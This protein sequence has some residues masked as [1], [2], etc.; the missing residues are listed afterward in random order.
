MML[1]ATPEAP[2]EEI[3]S[4]Q[5]RTTM[6][7]QSCAVPACGRQ[8]RLTACPFCD[9]MACVSCV[10]K[11]LL[12]LERNPRCINP[13]CSAD[14]THCL[15]SILPANFLDGRYRKVRAL[16]LFRREKALLP[17]TQE[18]ARALQLLP[19]LDRELELMRVQKKKLLRR[20]RRYVQL[21]ARLKK[22]GEILTPA[23][24][25]LE[26]STDE[27]R[28]LPTSTTAIAT[29]TASSSNSTT[30][31]T[32]SS[33]PTFLRACP[34]ESCRGYIRA[35]D[36]RCATCTI[37]VCSRC[38]ETKSA[39]NSSVQ[40]A[41]HAIVHVCQPEQLATARRL[42]EETRD[43]PRCMA[44]VSRERGGVGSCRTATC[45]RCQVVFHW[46]T[47]DV[48]QQTC[49]R[50]DW[51][52]CRW[53]Q[54]RR[55]R[56]TSRSS[57]LATIVDDCPERDHCSFVSGLN[58]PSRTRRWMELTVDLVLLKHLCKED[59]AFLHQVQ[60]WLLCLKNLLTLASSSEY[61]H[62][63]D[64]SDPNTN[65]DLRVERLN[66]AKLDDRT[67]MQQLW[68]RERQQEKRMTVR[69]LLA[70]WCGIG[71]E[72]IQQIALL[73][74]RWVSEGLDG[75][76][77]GQGIRTHL[78][79]LEDLHGFCRE[80]LDFVS[81]RFRCRV[82]VVNVETG[83]IRSLRSTVASRKEYVRRRLAAAAA[84]DLLA[85]TSAAAFTS[86][87]AA[88][89]CAAPVT[90]TGAHVSRVE[91]SSDGGDD[92]DNDDND[93]WRVALVDDTSSSDSDLEI[94]PDCMQVDFLSDTDEGEG[95]EKHA[96]SPAAAARQPAAALPNHTRASSPP[97]P[98]TSRPTKKM[99]T[100]H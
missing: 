39:S 54:R 60:G 77:I 96:A 100:K 20:M 87:P 31:A 50:I 74:Q 98:A 89:S 26:A 38:L 76:T 82:P 58:D 34:F 56:A 51:L 49:T 10:K 95:E 23:D 30:A 78:Q 65:E 14:W 90:P 29:S 16:L 21:R 4:G 18:R 99:K 13:S 97:S 72:Q 45:T 28:Q 46:D 64:P 35:S 36:W 66:N 73:L 15:Y 5:Q 79:E 80:K 53:L 61:R 69:E 12:G 86:A 43:C 40:D 7:A 93:A 62:A 83:Q 47:R 57:R 22:P 92:E 9:Y 68:V 32:A 91:D 75:R 52:Y 33:N 17:Q 88:A 2:N 37:E 63:A 94:E 84:N 6:F 48:V 42:L 8:R 81:Q 44:R 1:S 55:E 11:W 59:P 85:V 19:Q 25:D 24:V 27:E 41:T 67:W 71:F 70:L 3:L